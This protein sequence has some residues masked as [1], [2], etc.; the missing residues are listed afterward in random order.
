MLSNVYSMESPLLRT[1]SMYLYDLFNDN[2]L[3]VL[4]IRG[5]LT[6]NS[7]E[8]ATPREILLKVLFQD[9]GFT[10]DVSKT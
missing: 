10:F 2:V 3:C 8:T 6:S 5:S 4:L 9:K 7:G 1:Q